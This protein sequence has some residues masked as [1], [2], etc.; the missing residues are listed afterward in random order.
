[1]V[2]KKHVT[3]AIEERDILAGTDADLQHAENDIIFLEI[4]DH[5]KEAQVVLLEVIAVVKP[6]LLEVRRTNLIDRFIF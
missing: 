2:E 5:I 4:P 3:E 6:S 1:M